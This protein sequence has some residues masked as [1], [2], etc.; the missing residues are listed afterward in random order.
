MPNILFTNV[1]LLAFVNLLFLTMELEARSIIATVGLVIVLAFASFTSTSNFILCYSIFC[2]TLISCRPKGSKLRLH[3][4]ILLVAG[5]LSLPE[6][7]LNTQL[8]YGMKEMW[9]YCDKD[10]MAYVT[11]KVFLRIGVYIAVP[12]PVLLLIKP[13]HAKFYLGVFTGVIVPYLLLGFGLDYYWGWEIWAKG[14][15]VLLT[16]VFLA[17]LGSDFFDNTIK[18]GVFNRYL[19]WLRLKLRIPIGVITVLLNAGES[20]RHR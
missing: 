3:L 2:F 5:I 18:P 9:D 11:L 12:V 4:F 13:P 15:D 20:I 16:V 1:Q 14:A 10:H 17:A 19:R 7:W 6:A 8:L